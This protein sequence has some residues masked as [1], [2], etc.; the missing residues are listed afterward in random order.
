M[1]L[2]LDPPLGEWTIEVQTL[3][4]NRRIRQTFKVDEY[5]RL[6]QLLSI[7]GVCLFIFGTFED[8]QSEVFSTESQ[9]PILF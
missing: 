6:R 9:I 4:N 7:C 5:G 8:F 1:P 3:G 2:S